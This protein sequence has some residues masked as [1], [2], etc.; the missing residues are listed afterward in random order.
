[1]TTSPFLT[2]S[3]ILLRRSLGIGLQNL[4]R[5]A[6]FTRQDEPAKRLDVR[7]QTIGHYESGRNL[8]SVGDLEALLSLYNATDQLPHFRALRDGARRG[9][10]WWQTIASLPSW[11]DHYLGLES[12]AQQVD[13]FA[14][15][16]LPGL[17][18]TSGYAEA[19]VSAEPDHDAD[20]VRE[21]VS[22]RTQRRHI[23]DRPE[24]PATLRVVLDESVLYR[25]QGSP[26]VMREQLDALLADL[27]HPQIT[28]RILPLHA[29]G[30]RGQVD[31]PFMLL[32]F[33]QDMV[34][35][36]GVAYVEV[37]NEARY[38]EE[39]GEVEQFTEAMEDLLAAA[40]NLKD[41][42]QLIEKAKEAW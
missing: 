30:F 16:Y 25:R 15:M 26:A 3:P 5:A 2:S 27:H 1:M 12:G 41:S 11:F 9:E 23:L 13:A 21:L 8:P 32:G 7:R 18:Q 20:R 40:A 4:R 31:H 42:T 24:Q 39:L 10:N 17:L 36:N 33:P 14:P 37:L 34:G 19:I 38:Y 6:G 22:L 28:L 35:D 29:G